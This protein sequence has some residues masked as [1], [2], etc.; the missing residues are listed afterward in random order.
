MRSFATLT[1]SLTFIAPALAQTNPVADHHTHLLS[2]RGSHLLIAAGLPAADNQPASA[3]DVLLV[4]NAAHIQRAAVLS[5]AYLL[6]DPHLHLPNQA[7]EVNRE[8]DWTAAQAALYPHQLFAFCSVNPLAPYAAAAINHCA[9]IG[10]RGLKL[11]LAN[12][13]FDFKN[14]HHL[15]LLAATFRQANRR[16]MAILIHLRTGEPWSAEPIPIFVRDILP[17]APDVPIQIAHL[18]GW[19]GY[20]RATDAAAN[21]FATLCFTNPAPCRHLYFDISAVTL[22]PSAFNAAPGTDERLLADEQHDLPDAPQHLAAALHRLG[23]QRILFAT[24]WPVATPVAYRDLLRAQ[25][26]IPATDL[27]QIF[28]NLAP[29]FPPPKPPKPQA[30]RHKSPRRSSSPSHKSGT[31]RLQPWV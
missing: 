18:A 8:N 7:A 20:D 31:P 21:A 28:T 23:L 22:P 19:G 10:L 17:Q 15:H 9:A 30:A 29:Y 3:H 14:P 12:S 11:H 24:D 2:P 5:S 27:A 26:P 6:G 1:L 13:R 4:L 16:H 25:L